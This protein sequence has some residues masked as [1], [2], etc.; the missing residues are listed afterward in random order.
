MSRPGRLDVVFL[1]PD[2]QRLRPGGAQPTP[3][4]N[5]KPDGSR[6]QRQ[7]LKPSQRP[8]QHGSTSHPRDQALA[9]LDLE[10]TSLLAPRDTSRVRQYRRPRR[11]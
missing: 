7:R 1:K 9:G 3:E 4:T 6:G 11:R 8:L 10:K 2:H 5:S